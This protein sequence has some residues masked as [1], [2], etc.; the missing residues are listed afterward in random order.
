M[1][2]IE[3][4]KRKIDVP[5]S[6]EDVTLGLYEEVY[7]LQ[8]ETHRDRVALVAK[9]CKAEPE[10]LLDWPAEIFNIVVEHINFIFGDNPALPSA[11]VDINGTPFCVSIEDALTLGEWIDAEEVQK[12]GENI[13]SGVLSIV[14]RPVGEKYDP[15]ITDARREQ[16]AALPMV[17]VL[18]V[19][20]FFLQCK[21]IS[22]KHTQVSMQLL[23]AAALLPR[24]T[25][26]FLRRGAGIKWWRISHA[27]RYLILT[28][29]LR[30]QLRR[31]LRSC[32]TKKIK[33]RQ[34]KRSIS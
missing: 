1:V 26:L 23:E 11:T 25:N 2:T 33:M 17:K 15:I 6:W 19:M 27:V 12:R 4:N 8:P 34:T 28:Q 3:Y 7:F 20:A 22:E 31:Y 30:Y 13:I 5:Q 29:L 16:F 14:C 24:F 32:N 21:Q 18:G 9:L 10:L